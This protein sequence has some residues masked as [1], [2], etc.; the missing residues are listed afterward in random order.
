MRRGRASRARAR[1]VRALSRSDSLSAHRGCRPGALHRADLTPQ[2]APDSGSQKVQHERH[3]K[4]HQTSPI[5]RA[6]GARS[7]SDEFS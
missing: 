4:T 6:P 1:A 3:L 2:F 7:K 5:D